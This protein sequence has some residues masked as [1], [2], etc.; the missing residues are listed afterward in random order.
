MGGLPSSIH[1]PIYKITFADGRYV[2]AC[3][4][5]LWG[6]I[7]GN[8][9][10][11]VLTTTEILNSNFFKTK[12]LY[13]PLCKPIEDKGNANL[14]LHPY[15][16]G[17]ILGDGNISHKSVK[18]SSADV[19][20]INRVESFL[21]E[22]H[23]IQKIPSS[24]YEYSI[25]TAAGK[26]NGVT[27][28][29]RE[30][31]LQGSGSFTKFIPEPYKFTSIENKLLL[32]QG[33]FDTDGSVNKG[34]GIIYYTIS[35]ELA[36]GVAELIR[37]LGG[38]CSIGIKKS[39]KYTYK[40]EVRY[41]QDCYVLNVQRLPLAIKKQLFSLPRKLDLISAGQ[42]DNSGKLRIDTIEYVGD[43]DC[44]CISIDS[45][46]KL[47]LTNEYIVTH[48]T[49]TALALASKLKEKT[50]VVVHTVALRLS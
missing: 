34:N 13:V 47:Y 19:E 6:T 44:W 28:I 23:T 27:N 21:P 50:L 29:L 10:Y 48:N 40:D 12:R 46:D 33:L 9:K 17:A 4:E 36:S 3:G 8:N 11:K 26:A 24:K 31:G 5:H 30:L 37:S 42:Y 22:G 39:P 20:I 41:G 18:I 32:L 1:K 16:L 43:K 15:V 35:P 7:N 38:M 14:P 45:E 49:F 2:E 25:T